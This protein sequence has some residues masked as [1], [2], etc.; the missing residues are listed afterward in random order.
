MKVGIY[1]GRAISLELVAREISKVLQKDGHTSFLSP[2]Q[3]PPFQIRSKYDSAIFIIPFAPLFASSWFLIIRELR[4]HS[5]FPAVAYVVVE[6]RPVSRYVKDWMRDN[7]L[8]IA[9][10][11]FTKQML[12][13]V[14]IN[15]E[16][17]IP[18]GISLSDFE[19]I[20]QN[21]D[22]GRKLVFSKFP[23][24]SD[25]FVVF[26]TIASSHQRKGL[27]EY[28]QV[29]R[30]VVEM[31]ENVGFYIIT[32]PKAVPYFAGIP[33][34]YV[35]TGFGYSPNAISRNELLL[36]LSGFDY[37]VQPSLAESFCLPVLEAMALGRPVIHIDYDPL[38]SLTSEK[39]SIRVPFA[40]QRFTDTGEGIEYLMSYYDPND[41]VS[42]ILEAVEIKRS[43][44]KRYNKMQKEALK[45]AEEFDSFKLYKEFLRYLH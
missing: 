12:S 4:K 11:E 43:D 20:A 23:N 13:Y 45:R 3:E 15:C 41:F 22:A 24:R 36:L 9:N 17:V 14:N 19:K 5:G 32:E 44:E 10:S 26:G 21:Q 7:I 33:N 16:A 35:N 8:Y 30:T 39:T 2:V 18:H 27:A 6:G 40:E 31:D 37:Y 29:I 38:S 28:A 25:N 1:H 34:I 42:A